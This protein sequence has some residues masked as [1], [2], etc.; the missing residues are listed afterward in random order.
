[1]KHLFVFGFFIL[2]ATLSGQNWQLVWSDEFDG[3]ALDTDKW[4][5]MTG[6]GS[7]YGLDGWGNNELQYYKEENVKVADGM[8][9]ITA[10][11]EN[12]ATSQFTSGR[13]RTINLG[14]WT[15]GRFEFRAKMPVG[16]G[17]WA[18]IWMLPTDNDYGNWAA[19][20][21]I[22]I[23]EYLGHDTT[24]VHG[25]IH[26]GG[27]YPQNQSR[28]TD[29]ITDDTAFHSKF[30]TFAL[31]WEEGELRWY[32]DKERYQNLGTGM[33]YSSAAAFPA[34]FNRRFH[35]LINLAVGGNWPG[36]PDLSTIFPQDL[37]IDYVRVYEPV[38]NSVLEQDLQME[39]GQNHPNPFGD[40]SSIT[41]S[42]PSE[43][44]V[45]LEVFD[46]TGRKV[47]TLANE[48]YGPGSHTVGVEARI[49]EP[50]LYSYRLQAGSNTSTRQ[51]LIL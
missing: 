1:M 15:Y 6:T 17:L 41:F 49:L 24:R 22:D 29:Y 8:L 23:M 33:W 34:P 20:G 21:E 10:K 43:Q 4:S 38:Y 30:H 44:H 36:S 47:Q 50:G 25:T 12:V 9:T 7:E 51:M 26:Y 16:Q 32:V 27:P 14:D 28:G 39:L 37:V 13:I 42:L 3:D 5:Y 11:R 45:L 2:A 46:L 40:Y 31:E 48:R 35:L 18:A 19:S